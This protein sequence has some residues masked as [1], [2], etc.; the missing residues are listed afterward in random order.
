MHKEA[1]KRM[2]KRFQTGFCKMRFFDMWVILSW[3]QSKLYGLKKS[4]FLS[5][6]QFK[7]VSYGLAH[8]EGINQ[9]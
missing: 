2:L 1:S 5:L 9:K 4:F 8:N 7:L 6:K 3:R